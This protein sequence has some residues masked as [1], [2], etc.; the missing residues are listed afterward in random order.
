[1]FLSF[2]TVMVTFLML[3][4]I[5]R[6]PFTPHQDEQELEHLRMWNMKEP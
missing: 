4:I 3:I 5:P 2:F 1:M 6:R